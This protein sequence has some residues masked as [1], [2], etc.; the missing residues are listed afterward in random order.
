MVLCFWLLGNISALA[1]PEVQM[2]R[3]AAAKTLYTYEMHELVRDISCDGPE[4]VSDDET[5]KR[6]G[7]A[8]DCSSLLGVIPE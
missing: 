7:M 6:T 4:R 1:L 5:G 2:N 8:A 3:A